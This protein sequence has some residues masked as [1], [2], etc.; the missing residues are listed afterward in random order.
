MMT[1]QRK[2]HRAAPGKSRFELWVPRDLLADVRREAAARGL[3]AS[4]YV[5]L[6]L[7]EAVTR[8]ARRRK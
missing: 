8:D 7:G 5:R 4:G 6:R 2:G 3:T 1:E